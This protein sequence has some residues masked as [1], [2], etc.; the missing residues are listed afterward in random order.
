VLHGV[1]ISNY[2][3]HIPAG[4]DFVIIKA[5]EGETFTDN[6]FAGWWHELA[7]K[8]R[9]AYHYAHPSNDPIREAEHFLSVVRPVKGDVLVLDHEDADGRSAQHC[10]AWAQA[11][12]AHV[13]TRTGIKPVVYTFLSF[14]WE[15]HCAGLGSYPLW[16]A[17]PSRA[18][19]HPRVPAPWSSWALHQY[20]ESG[21]I[22]HDVLNGDG[23]AWLALASGHSS[24]PPPS[25]VPP[26]P[27]RI[28]AL[29]SPYMSGSDVKTW[30][31]QMHARGWT[32]TAD[33]I[34]GP[35]S[36]AVCRAFQDEK[37]LTVDGMVGP[38]TWSAAWSAPVT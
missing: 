8:R 24:T 11:W 17:D 1:D 18:M 19:G 21:G 3:D 7:G 28:L 14:A 22:D 27:G 34:Y 16:I 12:C 4:Q 26:F 15:G 10:A 37:G 20:G 5:T 9:G 13:H 30:Q 35:A 6:R 23:A 25:H 32:I 31:A 29:A 33:G 2:Q 38:E 36:A